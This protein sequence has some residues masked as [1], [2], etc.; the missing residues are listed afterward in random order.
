MNTPLEDIK[1]AITKEG[2]RH[3]LDPEAIRLNVKHLITSPHAAGH[4]HEATCKCGVL[5]EISTLNNPMVAAG[6]PE[7]QKALM[8]AYSEHILDE[9]ALMISRLD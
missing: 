6:A 3:A 9:L 1:L 2:A 7:F 8:N 5:L 4:E